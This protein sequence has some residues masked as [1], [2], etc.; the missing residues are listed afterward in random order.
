MPGTSEEATEVCGWIY[1]L[2]PAFQPATRPSLVLFQRMLG[3]RKIE[4]LVNVR[5]KQRGHL[6][7]ILQ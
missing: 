6:P 1:K 4:W 7:V 3:F 5:A 2:A